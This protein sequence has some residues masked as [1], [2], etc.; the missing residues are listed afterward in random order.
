MGAFPIF[1]IIALLLHD[2]ISIICGLVITTIIVSV[3][4]FVT[5]QFPEKSI[6]FQMSRRPKGAKCCDLVSF[7]SSDQSKQAG[8]PSGHMAFISYFIMC[9][10][11][12]TYLQIFLNTALWF[13]VAYD[14][15]ATNCHTLFQVMAG[16]V[17]GVMIG[18]LI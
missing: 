11:K 17:I 12:E 16:S 4:K 2:K 13:G 9:S 5:N 1:L 15:M 6:I 18:K 8:F 7:D 10:P 14:R 3:L